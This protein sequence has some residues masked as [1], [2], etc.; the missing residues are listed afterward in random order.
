MAQFT[1]R[2]IDDDIKMRLKRRV[3]RHGT[4]IEAEVRQI[5]RML[6]KMTNSATV[7]VEAAG[8]RRGSSAWV[9]SI[10]FPSSAGRRLSRPTGRHD[11]SRYHR[12]VCLDAPR[13]GSTG[14]VMGR[15]ASASIG[16]PRHTDR[17]HCAGTL[18]QF[19]ESKPPALRGFDDSG[20]QPLGL[21]RLVVA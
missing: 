11:D 15:P 4:N 12:A 9:L 1:V 7:L 5:L 2:N 8:L 3:V 13:A 6:S 10:R 17:G 20:H 16:F 19:V 21:I 14:S 18:R